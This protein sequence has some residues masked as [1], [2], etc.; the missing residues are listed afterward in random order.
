MKFLW[1]QRHDDGGGKENKG[2]WPYL[3]Q[4]RVE[5]CWP[6]EGRE[7]RQAQKEGKCTK[8]GPNKTR[9]GNTAE[10]RN[11]LVGIGKGQEG[12]WEKATKTD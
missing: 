7:T 4:V 5:G 3:N 2:T 1:A 6:E 11:W 8:D 10:S 9:W 12:P